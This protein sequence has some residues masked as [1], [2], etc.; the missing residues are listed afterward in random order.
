MFS[1]LTTLLG[2]G[3]HDAPL[4]LVGAG[5]PDR[6]EETTIGSVGAVCNLSIHTVILAGR[7]Q[8]TGRIA[9]DSVRRCRHP[10]TS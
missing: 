4:A 10:G 2:D 8:N 9:G 3:L 7:L 5:V 1:G 6:R